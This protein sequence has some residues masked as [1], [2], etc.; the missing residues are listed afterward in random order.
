LS[1]PH[2]TV[3]GPL[4]F[5]FL[6]ALG[7]AT[8]QIVA[9]MRRLRN[10]LEHEYAKPR[11]AEVSDAI[12]VAELFVQA[13][14]GKM[15]SPLESFSFGSGTTKTRGRKEVAKEFY[16]RFEGRQAPHVEVT[17]WDRESIARKNTASQS[18]TITVTA[19]DSEFIPLLKLIWRADWNCDMTELLRQF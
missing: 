6:Q 3:E 8:P 1:F 12:G 18:P 14:N 17:F 2:Q 16:V 11:K 10:L 15:R 7:V 4:K 5:R 13:C 9:R 19:V